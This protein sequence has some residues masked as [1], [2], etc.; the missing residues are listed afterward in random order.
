MEHIKKDKSL[1]LD[2]KGMII[3]KQRMVDRLKNDIAIIL[4]GLMDLNGID[5]CL[6][7]GGYGREEGSWIINSDGTCLPYNDYDILLVLKNKISKEIIELLRKKMAQE[8]GIRW[9][10]IGQKT[11]KELQKLRPSI[12]NYDLKYASKVIQGDPSILDFIPEID[13]AK[14]PLKEGETLFFT[15]LWT[16]LGS[17]DEKGFSVDR[18]GEESRFFRN[19]MAKAVLA[20]T[21][22]LLLQKRAYHPSYKERVNRLNKFYP[23][24]KDISEL[25]E[26]ALEEKLF[27]KA[28]DMTADE[29]KKLYQKVHHHFFSEMYCILT[30]YYS[31]KVDNPKEIERYLKWG[32]VTLIKRIGWIALRKNMNWERIIAVNLAQCYI[33]TAFNNDTNYENFLQ[34]GI[35]YIRYFDKSFA[36]NSSWDEARVRVAKLRMEV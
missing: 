28:P 3:I 26:W 31:R 4:N 24:R 14:L 5:A 19:Q 10:D 35:S 13:V 34:M 9:I 1:R 20:V 25:A 23:E 16:F 8:I 22:V 36:E 21:D 18:V 17:L 27:P 33:T 6:L 29:I 2:L 30:K 32:A 12:Y 15:R 11:P 7:Y